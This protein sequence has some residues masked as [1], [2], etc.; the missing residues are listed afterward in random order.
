MNESLSRVERLVGADALARL[1]STRVL[2]IGVGGVGSWCA[3][4]LVRSGIGHLTIVDS[5]CVEPSN[6]NRQLMATTLTLGQ[7]KVEAL[8]ARLLQIMPEAEVTAIQGTYSAENSASYHLEDY[9]YIIDCIDSLQHKLHLILT[10]TALPVSARTGRRPVFFSSM[11]AA[12]KVDSSLI[13]T[14]EFWK[15]EGCPLARALRN[16]MKRQKAFPQRKFQCVYAPGIVETSEPG[17]TFMHIT[18]QF[19]LRLAGLVLEN[20]LNS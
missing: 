19:G 14:A 20:A 3:E 11:G 9:D 6:L 12:R 7:P 2:L 4:S 13:R 8:R 16:H 10:A 5:D 18:A 15:V 17:G 1:R